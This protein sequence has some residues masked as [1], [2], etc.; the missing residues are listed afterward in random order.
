MDTDV[1]GPVTDRFID[2]VLLRGDLRPV[3]QTRFESFTSTLHAWN[4]SPTLSFKLGS[5][6]KTSATPVEFSC[7]MFSSVALTATAAV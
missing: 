1:V 7:F 4:L 5:V 3:P 2:S 6:K